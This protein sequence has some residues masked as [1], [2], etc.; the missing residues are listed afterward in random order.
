M[1]KLTK[2]ANMRDSLVIV[3]KHDVP[4]LLNMAVGSLMY[5]SKIELAKAK[6][7]VRILSGCIL[8]LYVGYVLTILSNLQSNSSK[9][10][11]LLVLL[12]CIVILITRGGV[13]EKI[14]VA[15]SGK[16]GILSGIC[17]LIVTIVGFPI[18]VGEVYRIAR[19]SMD[20]HFMIHLKSDV[21]HRLVVLF[22]TC[23][24]DWNGSGQKI[25][26]VEFEKARRHKTR[27]MS[28]GYVIS[29]LLKDPPIGQMHEA[30]TYTISAEEDL[31]SWLRE[32]K[33]LMSDSSQ[34]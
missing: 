16:T 19:D 13:I 32:F 8:T 34:S 10:Q 31:Q 27:L 2:E 18:L 5:S 29:N 3:P 20:R 11:L 17:I 26:K 24:E 30:D 23:V 7:F 4:Y 33:L 12:F 22:R 25:S 15:M 6:W 14:R 21:R 9:A 28:L 1:S